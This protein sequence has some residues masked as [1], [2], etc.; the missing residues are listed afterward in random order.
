MQLN[1][2]RSGFATAIRPDMEMTN[3]NGLSRIGEEEPR[4]VESL[5]VK[6]ERGMID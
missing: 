2:M 5:E 6:K 3:P 4:V 1:P